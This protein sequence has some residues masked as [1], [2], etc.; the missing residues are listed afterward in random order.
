MSKSIG[1]GPENQK[2][3]FKA[4]E[5]LELRDKPLTINSTGAGLGLVVSDNLA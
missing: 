1:I 2:K 3:L 4:F 5:K